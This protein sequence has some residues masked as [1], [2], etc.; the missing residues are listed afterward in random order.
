[1]N[2]IDK[3]WVNEHID[4]NGEIIIPDGVSV[5]RR[6]VFQGND[7]IKRV[8]MPDS[9]I[10]LDVRT[11]AECINLEEVKMSN[12]IVQI[13][14]KSFRNC[15]KLKSITIPDK[16]KLIYPNTF[17]NNPNLESITLNGNFEYLSA[18][19]FQNCDNLSEVNINGT[20]RIEYNAF[21]GK[22]NIKR[23]VIDGKEIFISENERLISIQKVGEKVAIVTQSKENNRFSTQCINLAKN[24][25]KSL[26]YLLYLPD[27]GK[28]S[29]AV[30]SLANLS[31]DSLIK[32][33]ELGQTQFYIYGGE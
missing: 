2:N 6:D 29:Y 8:I 32:F 16:V 1:M 12:N 11:F 19:A 13:G 33:K 15:S 30:Y 5:I 27:D 4:S 23:I 7:R 18:D 17:V 10:G 20:E 9:I 14:M 25:S 26:D 3:N 21:T 31:L 28:L 22:E 24:T